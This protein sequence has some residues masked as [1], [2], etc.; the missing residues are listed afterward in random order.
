[1]L[2]KSEFAKNSILL[3]VGTGMSQ[4][5]PIAIQPYIR[6]VYSAEEFGLF[7]QYY[8]IVSIV[9]IIA[10]F[11]YENSIVIP[12]S[13]RSALHLFSGALF[14]NLLTSCLLF[15][16]L[17]FAG[18]DLF[19]YL[20]LSPDLYHYYWLIPISVLLI[21]TNIS[22]N[23]WLTRKKWF[24]GIVVNKISRRTAEASTRAGMGAIGVSGGV[25]FGSIIGDFVNLLVSIFQFK[26]SGGTTKGVTKEE[27]KKELKEQIE[28]PKHALLP[29]VLNVVSANLS[30][31][32]FAMFYT[33]AIVGQ[34]N[35]SRELLS[36]PLALISI[37]LSQVL[38]QR[39]AEDINKGRKIQRL[40]RNNFLMLL[41]MAIVGALIIH[42]F[43]V[44]I[45]TFLF[46]DKW[47]LSGEISEILVFSFAIKFIVSPLSIS[48]M[49]LKRMKISAMWQ[50]GY[51]ALTLSLFLLDDLPVETFVLYLTLIDLVAYA[52]Y[53]FLIYFTVKKQDDLIDRTA[54]E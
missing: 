11:K 31:F 38:F 49:A 54:I 33:D 44:P 45:F 14:F 16:V 46:G 2:R 7:A 40:M 19:N 52:V 24:K 1:M 27:V 21:S 37:S 18:K 25:I 32:L 12:K 20:E 29:T 5:L 6:R 23:Y 48:F 28:F 36:V 42:F 8:S 41:S 10:G 39:L 47:E 22:I 3:M 26:K 30:V 13:D 53:G 4:L 15:L 35:A 9:A 51:F 50:I 17:F 34:Y 43:A